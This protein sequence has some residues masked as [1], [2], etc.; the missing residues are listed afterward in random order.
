MIDT[1][2]A[3]L[4][5]DENEARHVRIA[6]ERLDGRPGADR[7]T[8]RHQRVTR[9]EQGEVRLTHFASCGPVDVSL[10]VPDR[11]LLLHPLSLP[12]FLRGHNDRLLHPDDVVRAVD[13]L[14]RILM[15]LEVSPL[16]T[17]RARRVDF[18]FD[19]LLDPHAV[20]ACLRSL[21]KRDLRTG[22]GSR[23]KRFCYLGE[24]VYWKWG[25][26]LREATLYDKY[27]HATSQRPYADIAPGTVRFEVR[28]KAIG[29][30][31]LAD[32]L[33]SEAVGLAAVSAHLGSDYL[34]VEAALDQRVAHFDLCQYARALGLHLEVDED[35]TFARLAKAHGNKAPVGSGQWGIGKRPAILYGVHCLLR[36]GLSEGE[37]KSALEQMGYRKPERTFG[38]FS[39]Q[40]R[41]AGVV[42]GENAHTK[43]PGLQ[44]PPR[45]SFAD[46]YKRLVAEEP[47]PWAKA[48][49]L[50]TTLPAPKPVAITPR[51]SLVRLFLESEELDGGP[52][53][54]LEADELE[55]PL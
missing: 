46:A 29:C 13:G 30:D 36:D 34:P 35:Q 42:P 26:R 3:S 50:L 11:R 52:L 49:Q 43:L 5:L 31:R 25:D 48:M 22:R 28:E 4:I 17:W 38:Q 40:L 39:T 23:P 15:P 20:G 8:W 44:L 55:E 54:E 33:R 9:E 2:S 24:T 19:F 51:R 27:A 18:A 14:D 45:E 12:S 53:A 47:E 41:E 32:T 7:G 6:L 21:A 16:R 37:V 1:I 10:R